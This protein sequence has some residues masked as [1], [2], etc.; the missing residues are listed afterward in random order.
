M[1]ED[2]KLYPFRF[3][4][5]KDEYNW[6]TDEFTL[7]DLGYRDSLVRDGWLAGNSL[8]EVMDMYMDRVVGENAFNFWGRQFPVQVKRITVRGRMPLRVHPDA[9]TATDRYDFL[10]REKLWYIKHAGKDATLLLGFER[11]ADASDVYSRCLDGTVDAIMH[12]ITPRKGEYYHIAPGTPHAASGDVQIVEVSESSPLD[13]CLCAWGEQVSE[14]EF[15]PALN[16]IDALDF[17]NYSANATAPQMSADR[18]SDP[19]TLIDLPQFTVRKLHV[20]KPVHIGT[21]DT[22]AFTVL[23]SL[24]GSASIELPVLGQTARYALNEGETIL[25]SAECS[26]YTITADNALLLATTINPRTEPDSYINPSAAP[27]LPED[28][29]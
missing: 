2:K 7:A 24:E 8:S 12:K 1:E 15:D 11:D 13:F 9:E 19:Q 5:L 25:I 26:D 21:E 28:E 23:T 16:I 27:T 17:I 10:G 22:D 14:D 20:S 4:T 3:Y 6:G 29:E 18:P